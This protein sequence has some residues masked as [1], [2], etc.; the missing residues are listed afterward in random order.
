VDDQRLRELEHKRDTE[1]L[2]DDEADELGRMLAEQEGVPYANAESLAQSASE[3]PVDE[4]P[5]SEEELKTLREHRDVQSK[6]A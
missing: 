2:T 5:S 3:E 6:S 4:T 1:G